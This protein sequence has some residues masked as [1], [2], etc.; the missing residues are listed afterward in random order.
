MRSSIAK[1]AA[2]FREERI[3][4]RRNPA[5][6]GD[7][8]CPEG[9]AADGG[10]ENVAPILSTALDARASPDLAGLSYRG[11]QARETT[12]PAGR[13]WELATRLSYFLTSSAPDEELRTVAAGG[14]LNDEKVLTAQARRLLKSDRVRRLATEFGCQYLHVR[15]VATL[16]EMS[17]RHFPGFLDLRDDM[18][19]EVTRFF[20]DLFQTMAA[21]YPSSM[22]T[23]PS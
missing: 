18:Q 20:I 9:L 11:E 5:S 2:K 23:I 12:G 6:G 10:R 22:R 21:C 15:D 7:R 14:Q 3:R 1:A 16:D 4:G 17:E 19:E 8:L 13:D